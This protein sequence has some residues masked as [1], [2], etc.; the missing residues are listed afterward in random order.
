VRTILYVKGSESRQN[1]RKLAGVVAS[2]H[3]YKWNLQA[4]A[5]PASKAEAER[6]CRLW[7]PDGIIVNLGTVPVNRFFYAHAEAQT[8]FFQT[9]VPEANSIACDEKVIAECA[10]RE[11]LS[12]DLASYAYLPWEVPIRWSDMRRQAFLSIL[13]LH[14]RQPSV[15]AN[16]RRRTS[17]VTLT[18]RLADWL[19]TLP[20]PAGV[21]AAND[22][23][24]AHVLAACRVAGLSV[25]EDI[26]VIGVDDDIERCESC[27][28]TLS[29]V[30]L[31][32]FAAGRLAAATLE[33]LLKNKTGKAVA[34]TYAPLGVTR[35]Q[36][37]R[38]LEHVDTA[39]SAAL[40]RIR[41]EA[42]G[43]LSAAEA[44]AAF[45]CSRRLAEMR[46]RRAV[47]HSVLQE[48]RSVRLEKAKELLRE[49]QHK[50]EFVA[51][52]CG[53]KTLA[54][55]SAFFRAETGVPPSLWRE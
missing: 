19:T 50:L 22:E 53:Y 33:K 35:R 43:G 24:A 45:P 28:P 27:S 54:A 5:A 48:I 32:Y 40:E 14:G 13:A 16:G 10:A 36:S 49:G 42:C 4:V 17:P 12:L 30:T 37:T 15:F 9:P 6:L 41:R 47:G 25:P 55:F 34:V 18:E 1:R 23:M 29:S 7:K 38:R 39:V 21:F 52:L 2:A 26:A 3:A 8:L 31:D 51:N 44:L 46:F 11:L 20:K